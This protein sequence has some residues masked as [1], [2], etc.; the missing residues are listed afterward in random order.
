MSM[1]RNISNLPGWRTPRKI[2]VIESDDWGSIRMPS[3]EAFAEL[4]DLGIDLS[5]GDGYRYNRY[6][7]LATADD[8]G[9][10]FDVLSSVKGVDGRPAAVTA[11][12]VVANPD[13]DKIRSTGYREYHYETFTETLKRYPGCQDSFR[14]WREGIDNGLFIPQF[15]GREH[16]NVTGWLKLLQS[17]NKQALAAFDHGLWGFALPHEVCPIS[18]QAAFDLETVAEL[19]YLESVIKDGL[20]LFEKLFGYKATFFV[21]PNGPFCSSLEKTAAECGVRFM[22]TAKIHREPPGSGL[23]QTSYRWLGK[24][25]PYGQRY[26]TRNCFFE[27]SS[28]GRDWIDTCLR[29]IGIAFR[30]H[31]PAVISSHRVNYIG[32]LDR[33]NRDTGLIQLK[34]LLDRILSR[35]PDVE[36][37]TSDK[38][39]E[40]MTKAA[41]QG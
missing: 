4:E 24:T 23:R 21:P 31:K 19:P 33:A 38:L 30:W 11:V 7:S 37:M 12:S 32:A 3:N 16:L 35:W 8:L 27:P 28:P 15:H 1:L 2:V 22:S 29:E 26:I 40:C 25:N 39:G 14:L 10:L 34:T 9:G 5:S 17:G 36:F 6:D 18:L 13:F 41:M 20:M